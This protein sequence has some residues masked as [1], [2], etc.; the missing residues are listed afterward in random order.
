ML[1]LVSC[2]IVV[3]QLSTSNS[4]QRSYKVGLWETGWKALC[5]KKWKIKAEAVEERA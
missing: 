3:Q 2:I 5:E 1:H 4:H